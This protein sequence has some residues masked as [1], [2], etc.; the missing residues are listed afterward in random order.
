MDFSEQLFAKFSGCRIFCGFSGGADSTAA[1]LLARKLQLRFGYE[2]QAV[3]FNHHLRGAESDLEAQNAAAFAGKLDIPFQCIDLTIPAG[4]NLESAARNARL[5]AW[6]KLLSPGDAVLLGHHADDR[7]ENLLIR[8]CRGSNANGLS[9]MKA[10]SVVDGV[11]FLRPLLQM[12]RREI[13]NFLR[14]NGVEEWAVDSSN[15]STAFLRNYLR[16]RFLPELEKLF[17]GS[18]K[19]MERSINALEADADFISS[20]VNAIPPEKKKSISFWKEQHDAVRIRLLRELTGVIPTYDL[21]ERVNKELLISS[22]ELRRI[23]VNANTEIFLRHDTI[24]KGYAAPEIPEP[25]IW[26]WQETPAVTRG[27]WHFSARKLTKAG[28]CSPD[29]ACFDAD[30]LP[31]RLE[32]SQ[33]RPG[34]KMIPFGTRREEKIKKLRTDRRIPADHPFPV[35]RAAGVICWAVMVRHA[36]FAAVTPASRNIVKFEFEEY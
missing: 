21:L 16:N 8:L 28:K 20:F 31:A 24:E 30:Q 25:F 36:A 12:T 5:E 32:I 14:A 15:A 18:L 9:S 17:P 23:P 35:V 10:V 4:T 11:T 3:H 2:L 1:L 19:G 27:K 29:C 26:N 34:E 13:E 6:K 22:G 7:K 33:V